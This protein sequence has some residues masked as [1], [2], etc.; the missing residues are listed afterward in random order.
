MSDQPSDLTLRLLGLPVLDSG[1]RQTPLRP[2][3]PLWLLT[4]LACHTGPVSRAEVLDLLYPDI[5]EAAARNRLRNLLHRLRHSEAGGGLGTSGTGLAWTAWADVRTFREACQAARWSEALDAYR[6][7]LLEAQHAGEMPGFEAWLEAEREDLQSGWTQ[8][9]L[10]HAGDLE[11]TGQAAAALPWL[12]QVL[13]VCP[14]DEQAVQAALRCATL[15]GDA[16]EA[17]RLYQGFRARLAGDLGLDPSPATTELYRASR[18][19][20]AVSAPTRRTVR[21]S[22]TP[23]FGRLE[24]LTWI[25]ERLDQPGAQLLTLVGPGGAGKTRLSQEVLALMEQGAGL[26]GSFVPLEAATSVDEVVSALAAALGLTLGGNEPPERQLAAPLQSAPHLLVLDNLEQLLASPQ[27]A[28]LLTLLTSLLDL[29][30]G[31]RLLVTSRVRLGLQAEWV[32]TLGGLDYPQ[33]AGLE[34]AARSSAVRLFVERASR[35][36]PGFSLT[37]GNVADLIR[38]CQLTEG[39][40]LALELTAAWMGTFGPDDLVAELSASLD[41][42][43]SDAPDRPERHRSLR[44]AFLQSW[45]L[46]NPEERR[47]L[48]RLSVFRGGFERP[49]A[50]SVTG[51]GLRSLL[52]LADHSLLKRDLAGRYVLHEVVRQYAAEELQRD[53]DELARARQAHADWY[54]AL[55]AEAAPHLHGADQVAWLARL[56]TEHDNLRAALVWMQA[57]GEAEPLIATANALHWFWYVRG[58]HREGRAW[59]QAALTLPGTSGSARAAA[60]SRAGGLARDLGDYAE[61]QALL[62]EA[63]DLAR[64]GRHA[65]LEAE[66]LHGLGLG[67]RDRGQLDQAR[68]RL[69]QAGQVQRQLSDR[70]ALASTLNDLGI[71]LAI[72][73]DLDGARPLFQESLDLKERI[74]DRQ[75]VAYA[76]A[77]FANTLSDLD[78]YRRLT[79]QSLSIKRELGDR[80]GT[81]NS[82]FNLADLHLNRGDLDTARTLLH[83]ALDLYWQ[84]GRQRGIAAAL[85]E[86]AKLAAHEHDPETCLLLAGAADALLERAGV[87][88]QGFE[89]G[90][91]LDEARETTGETGAERYR[92]GRAMPLEQAVQRALGGGLGETGRPEAF[93]AAGPSLNA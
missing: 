42:L 89:V 67:L 59:L 91:V 92:Q 24:E 34:A 33:A 48:M 73:D 62:E 50:L 8:A 41:V 22:G 69:E 74:G 86:C 75:G 45:R 85:I 60:L 82:L 4:F 46:L 83:E 38:L 58:Y 90:S 76:L 23:I 44:A 15:L 13:T 20:P 6:G 66:A 61:S 18:T 49:A 70:W 26:A 36:R 72:Q 14:Y 21:G 5:D 27:R 3:A 35:V 12:R 57:R 52:A 51:G 29:A 47:T 7:P 17:E 32:I 56:Q 53:A 37:P 84:M 11:R 93:R 87:P 31:L 40:P 39:L 64:A 63:L 71:V 19:S 9:A 16:Q 1:G 79:E 43:E 68:E 81:A 10:G 65:G 30:P 88:A 80:Q 25:R 28:A 55:A 78:E 2:E 54:A 77:N